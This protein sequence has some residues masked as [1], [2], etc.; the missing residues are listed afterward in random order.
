MQEGW[1]FNLPTN[2]VTLA[3]TILFES[4]YPGLSS[5]SMLSSG[6]SGYRF[7]NSKPFLPSLN[8]I[9]GGDAL[10]SGIICGPRHR[11]GLKGFSAQGLCQSIGVLSATD[12]AINSSTS[13]TALICRLRGLLRAVHSPFS[14]RGLFGRK[15]DLVSVVSPD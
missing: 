6:H 14:L 2:Y 10:I 4:L 3:N 9:R 11:S 13:S 5:F 12:Q 7:R 1:L 15:G 8:C